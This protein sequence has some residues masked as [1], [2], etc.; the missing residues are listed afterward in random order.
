MDTGICTLV[1]LDK[2]VDELSQ[3]IARAGFSHISLSHD[4]L[5][6][7][8]NF[9]G[10]ITE[11]R[12][13]WQEVGL[14]L[15]YIHAPLEYYLDLASLDGQVRRASIEINKLA[16]SACS[17][18]DGRAVVAHIMNGPLGPGETTEQRVE[19]GLESLRELGQYASD[20][21]VT[22]CVENLPLDMDCGG[23]SLAVIRAMDVPGVGVCLDSCHAWI[24]NPKAPA[25]V[26]ELAPR[27]QVTHFSDT[28]GEYDSHLI[29]GEG[30]ADFSEITDE[31]GKAGYSGVIDLE[32]SLWMLRQ[33]HEKDA[34]HPD[35]PVPC[36][37][38]HYLERA[39]LAAKRLGEQ[40]KQARG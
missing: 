40:L 12:Q 1:D 33:R 38:A 2:P 35:D 32:C 26:R 39:Q 36:S 9:P 5:H 21:G 11:L 17:R 20:H 14:R 6:A 22:L 15:N 34:E 23:V 13:L 25:L 37:A 8:Y 27:V 18:L 10:R 30:I 28:M 7:G 19:A 3:M 31:L 16:L 4:V 29:P 24:K